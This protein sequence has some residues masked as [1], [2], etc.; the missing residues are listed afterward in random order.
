MNKII[1]TTLLLCAGFIITGCEKTYSVEEFKKNEELLKEWAA[2]CGI[3][4]QSKNCQ[5]AR[6]AEDQLRR[7]YYENLSKEL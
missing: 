2:R 5:N 1:I 3:G 4:G 7:E 6:V